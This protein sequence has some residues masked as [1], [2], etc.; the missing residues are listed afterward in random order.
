MPEPPQSAAIVIINKDDAGLADTLSAVSTVGANVAVTL[1]T[2]VVD[3]SEGRLDWIRD[4]FPEV[5]WLSF[6]PRTDKPTI[7]EQRNHGLN[8]SNSDIVVFIDASC[9]P[10][11]GW[12]DELLRP[13]LHEGELIVAGR[14]RSAGRLK[15]RDEAATFIQGQT[16]L[17]EAPTINMAVDR[18][19]FRNIG[20]FDETFAY[21]S[22]VDF[23]WRA[24]QAGF[25]IRASPQAIVTHDWGGYWAEAKRSFRYGRGR[26]RLYR[27]HTRR[28]REA[29]AQ[30]LPAFI[31][32]V[33]L[34]VSPLALVRR[35]ILLLL[36]VPLIK[37]RRHRPFLTVADHLIYAAGILAEIRNE[38]IGRSAPGH[39]PG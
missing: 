6:T 25:R 7:A 19:V 38:L 24:T 32:P 10:A 18:A 11:P 28:V 1:E 36:L 16:Y 20:G 27:K 2:I 13:M 29:L 5:R 30:D 23:S 26:Y 15:I 22:D 14:H 3:A 4:R 9:I 37:N 17:R 21:G 33:F 35:W 8:A 34:L 31:Y 39:R 12:L